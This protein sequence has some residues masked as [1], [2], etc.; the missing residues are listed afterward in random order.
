MA[1]EKEFVRETALK[2]GQRL[3]NTYCETA[4]PLLIPQLERGLFDNNWRIRFSSVQLLGDFLFRISGM[5]NV[6]SIT[7]H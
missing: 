4:I 7:I 5:S 2:A 3:I 1:D 6:H